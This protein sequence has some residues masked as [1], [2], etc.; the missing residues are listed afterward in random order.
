MER[1]KVMNKKS[2]TQNTILKVIKNNKLMIVGLLVTIIGSILAVL[3]PPQILRKVV[4]NNLVNR[5]LN[6]LLLLAIL[7]LV[8]LAFDGIFNFI[9]EAL[10]TVLGQKITKELRVEMMAK[11]ERLETSYFSNNS[12]GEIVSRFT[13]DIDAV[14]SMFTSGFVDIFIDSFKIIGIIA[15]I[16]IFSFSLGIVTLILIPVIYFITR[17]FQRKML[18][19]QMDNRRLVSKVNNHISESVKNVEMI[20]VYSKE[21]YMEDNYLNSLMENYKTMDK[22]NFFDSIYSPTIQII[23]AII[24]GLI[25]IL[26]TGELN[27]LGISLGMVAA[28]IDLISNIFDPIDSLGMELQSLQESI[29]GIK[30]V[31]EFYSEREDN[32]KNNNIKAENILSSQ[33]DINLEYNNVTFNY[34]KDSPVLKNINLNIN[35]NDKVTFVG[36]TG[37]GKTTLF[38]LST[39]ILKPTKGSITINGVEVYDIPNSEKR[40]IFGYVDQSFHIINGT[41]KEQITLRDESIT[42]KEVKEAIEFVG[43]TDYINS[44]EYGLN[45]EVKNE[46]LFSQGQKQLLAIARATVMKPQILILDEIT[47]NLDSITEKNIVSVLEKASQGRTILSISHRLSSINDSDTV[48][49]IDD[50]EIKSKGTMEQ[51][52]DLNEWFSRHRKLEQLTW[53]E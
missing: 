32:R 47:A 33:K 16:C 4:D 6:G 20:K 50:G 29:A 45:T 34:D 44:L 30:R 51:I 3:I 2:L 37:V 23:R 43:L 48:V 26:S 21:K 38:K 27:Y 41:V 5:E 28:T 17:V 40:K 52:L 14:N 10:I 1:V 7:Y 25:V 9:K 46:S 49:V 13:N 12:S 18:K 31:D 36:R 19:A 22:V 42:D 8:V 11:L 53:S 15:S 35:N 39:G 24:I